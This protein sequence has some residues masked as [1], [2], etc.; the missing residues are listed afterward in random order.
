MMI[1][2]VAGGEFPIEPF[3][4]VGGGII[5]ALIGGF[6][7]VWAVRERKN[8]ESIAD[9]NRK[10][11]AVLHQVKNSH[12]TNLRDDLDQLR[13]EMHEQFTAQRQ[14]LSEQRRRIDGL[15]SHVVTGK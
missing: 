4:S 10:L 1:A 2:V 7:T 8:A 5:I 3:I 9:Q 13:D 6:A 12:N 11:D 15:Y 14:E